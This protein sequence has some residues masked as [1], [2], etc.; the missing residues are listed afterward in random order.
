ML[1]VAVKKKLKFVNKYY[2][3]KNNII[4]YYLSSNTIH[5]FHGIRESFITFIDE[6]YIY[7]IKISFLF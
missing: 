3:T 1:T 7:R 4:L 2:C 5:F 6:F